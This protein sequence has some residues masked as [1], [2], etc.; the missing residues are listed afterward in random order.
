M[1]N[2]KKAPGNDYSVAEK[3]KKQE[4][5]EE[6]SVNCNTEVNHENPLVVTAHI[7]KLDYD[8]I[9]VVFDVKLMDGY[10]VYRTVDESDPYIPMK[11]TFALPD[12]AVLGD[13]FYPIAKPFVK[14]GTTIY[15]SNVT[16][17]QN[18][19]LPILPA[20]IK[21]TF[22]CQCCDANVC[23]PPLEKEFTFTVE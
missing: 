14:D 23:M 17:R 15:E 7:Q 22:E 3:R 13:A 20:T 1:V 11:L 5:S 2:D 16:I 4:K 9:D 8:G 21:C 18:V 6:I 12:G 19:K 10:H